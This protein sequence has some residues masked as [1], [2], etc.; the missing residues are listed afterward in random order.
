M[1]WRTLSPW[2][3]E[4]LPIGLVAWS[5]PSLQR[6]ARQLDILWPAG[7]PAERAFRSF[8]GLLDGWA[9]AAA[10]AQDLLQ[11]V[12]KQAAL[13]AA[14]A[15]AVCELAKQV[16]LHSYMAGAGIGSCLAARDGGTAAATAGKLSLKGS[17]RWC[18][19]AT[20]LWSP[21]MLTACRASTCPAE[22]RAGSM[23]GSNQA[24]PG[25]SVRGGLRSLFSCAPG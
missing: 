3:L 18:C 15:S 1:Q 11:G 16:Q 19:G 17:R 25:P 12:G 20:G 8:T 24:L 21:A 4:C 23:H 7:Q 2:H 10:L 14:A 6:C 22:P 13:C 9:G 5:L